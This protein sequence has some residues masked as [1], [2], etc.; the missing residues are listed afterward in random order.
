M[1]KEILKELF[2]IGN[3]KNVLNNLRSFNIDE[4]YSD[5]VKCY[6]LLFLDDLKGAEIISSKY[7]K[8][9]NFLLV[10]AYINF[11]KMSESESFEIAKKI[12][13]S[14]N[15]LDYLK[16]ESYIIAMN[17]LNQLN[18][19]EKLEEFYHEALNFALSR[20]LFVYKSII[21]FIFYLN[22]NR[23]YE[24][25]LSENALLRTEFELKNYGNLNYYALNLLHNAT[26]FATQ[27]QFDQANKRID[28][29]Y[30]LIKKIGSLSLLSRF[31]LTKY[32][33]KVY[34]NQIDIE[35]LNKALQY[36]HMAQNYV[37]I[38]LS[39]NYIISYYIYKKEIERA[40]KFL[41]QYEK[42]T[43]TQTF[44]LL[45]GIGQIPL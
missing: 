9:E 41:I 27:Y 44:Y 32:F 10:K 8:D 39:L 4:Y 28:T 11:N 34:E 6:A 18:L 37:N 17:S 1:L 5:V 35:D 26:I 42:L 16:L 19:I 15:V 7:E 31:F 14:N 22:L 30:E 43:F 40:E 2:E 36:A 12:I 13:N 3:Y 21:D 23:I 33:V 25:K 24:D 45:E 20:N 29:A 38:S